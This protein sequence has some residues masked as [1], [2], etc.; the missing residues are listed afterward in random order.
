MAGMAGMAGIHIIHDD[1]V[2]WR[3]MWA[4]LRLGSYKRVTVR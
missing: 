1:V 4:T 2:W 3:A